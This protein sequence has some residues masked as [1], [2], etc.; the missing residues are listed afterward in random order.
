MRRVARRATVPG[1]FR[2]PKERDISFDRSERRGNL[3]P[4][5]RRMDLRVRVREI[6]GRCIGICTIVA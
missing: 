4:V 2:T 3:N 5:V 6:I 1:A